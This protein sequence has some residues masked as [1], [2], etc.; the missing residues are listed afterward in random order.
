[1]RNKNTLVFVAGCRGQLGH[2]ALSVLPPTYRVAGGDLPEL[3]ITAPES[4]IATLGPS[5]ATAV[6]NCAAYTQVDR[7][8]QD[9]EAARR[10]NVDGPLLLAKFAEA[11]DAWLVH[12]STDYVFDGMRPPPEPYTESDRP[13]PGTHYG[14][15]KLEGEVAV[16]HTATRHLIVR[17]AWLYGH[18][19]NNFLK[20]MLRLA[21]ANP[22]KPIRVVHDQ[23]GCPT[24]SYRLAEQ[25]REL[26]G[27]GEPGIYHATGSGHCTW[28][29]LA[30]AFLQRMAVPHCLEPCTTADYPTPARR[31]A[32]SILANQR[33][34]QAGLHLMRPWQEDL[35]AYVHLHREA[36]I[37]EQRGKLAAP[38]TR[39]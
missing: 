38:P 6:L 34:Q 36:L 7:A 37:A 28:F 24:W 9:R 30:R 1:M 21:L 13:R 8:E 22:E 2:D 39:A 11:H 27:K 35:E 4:V 12:V 29:E 32:N 33:L 3:D 26:L 25:I 31:P 19:G 23:F 15:T 10:V 14:L 5:G 18:H 17:T 20:T 16:R